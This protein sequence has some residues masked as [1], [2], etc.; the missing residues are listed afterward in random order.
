MRLVASNGSTVG[1]REGR[2]EVC[3]N[4]TWGTVSDDGWSVA[5]VGVVCRQLGYS[6]FSEFTVLQNVIVYRCI[7]LLICVLF[8]D[9]CNLPFNSDVQSL[10]NAAFGQG[11]GPIYLT[12]VTC[13]A[14]EI[15]LIDCPYS[16]DVSGLTHAD[17]AGAR[18]SGVRKYPHEIIYSGKSQF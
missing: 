8:I 9:T 12:N 5:E 17:D 14:T 1:V 13:G 7:C 18:C 11:T 4:E 16:S 10:P 2:V 3:F 15:R 6:R